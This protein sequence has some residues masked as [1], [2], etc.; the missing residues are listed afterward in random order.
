MGAEVFCNCG[1]DG[2]KQHFYIEDCDTDCT[3]THDHIKI[4]VNANNLSARDRVLAIPDG[5]N[6]HEHLFYID[7]NGIVEMIREL[8][9]LLNK[10]IGG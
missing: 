1:E 2:C 10:M 5:D 6:T 4:R 3:I 8:R 7:A 9:S